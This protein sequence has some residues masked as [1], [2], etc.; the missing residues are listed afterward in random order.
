MEYRRVAAFSALWA[1][2][3]AQPER[4][5]DATLANH[6]TP[7]AQRRDTLLSQG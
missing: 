6:L 4:D 1:E 3:L 2:T 7:L 5:L